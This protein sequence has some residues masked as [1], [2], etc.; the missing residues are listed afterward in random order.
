MRSPHA[1]GF[2]IAGTALMMLFFD[3]ELLLLVLMGISTAACLAIDGWKNTRKFLTAMTVGGIC[4]NIAVFMGAWSYSNAGYLFAPLW[5]PVGWGMA[6]VLL[7][8]MLKG[9]H[10]ADFHAFAPVLAV[11]GTVG[12]G[13]IY[14]NEIGTLAAFGAVTVFFIAVGVYRRSELAEGAMAALLGTGMESLCIAAGNWQY[15]IAALGT[16]IWLPLC[17]F[18]AYLIMK[19]V[20]SWGKR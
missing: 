8:E 11:G 15:S 17:W 1:L 13:L 7:D 10:E 6:V 5:L 16:P 18:N 9:A 14:S 20:A 19:R 2:F 4:E 12:T 3:E